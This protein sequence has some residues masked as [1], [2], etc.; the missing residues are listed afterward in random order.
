MTT[1]ADRRLWITESGDRARAD[2]SAHAPAVRAA[3]HQG[4]DDADYVAALKVLHRM[5]RNVGGTV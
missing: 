3:I 1:H 2:I 5:I 4:I